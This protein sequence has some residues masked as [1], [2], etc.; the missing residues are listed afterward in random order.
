MSGRWPRLTGSSIGRGDGHLCSGSD[1]AVVQIHPNI[2]AAGAASRRPPRLRECRHPEAFATGAL[3]LT[4][5][6]D[7]APFAGFARQPG[8]STVQGRIREALSI[9]LRRKVETLGLAVRM[10]A[11]M[12]SDKW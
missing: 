11:S 2:F 7:G 1:T 3:A 4:V 10:R 5:S 12:R 9:G 8:L 6:Y